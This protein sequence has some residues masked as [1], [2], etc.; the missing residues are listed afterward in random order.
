MTHICVGNLTIIVS[1]N[2]LSPYRRQ[3]IILTDAQTLWIGPLGT[4]FSEIVL[5]IHTFSFK[6][7][8]LK[9]SYGKW[10]PFCLGLNV[11]SEILIKIQSFSL[12]KMHLKLFS[13]KWRSFC[14]QFCVDDTKWLWIILSAAILASVLCWS[15]K[16][17]SPLIPISA[18]LHQINSERARLREATVIWKC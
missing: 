13:T 10:R 18:A 17:Y 2:G 8:H 3:A 5:E 6:K 9:M 7:M 14:Y 12:T 15:V 1:D 16:L 4:K 11:L